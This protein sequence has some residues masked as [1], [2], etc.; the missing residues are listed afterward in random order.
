MRLPEFVTEISPVRETL[1][2]AGQGEKVLRADVKEAERQF[3]VSTATRGLSLWESDYS[4]ENQGPDEARRVAVWT[5]LAGGKTLTPEFLEELC[6]SLGKGDWGQ[7]NED[8]ANWTVTAYSAAEG[9]VP[10]GAAVLDAAIQRLK[11]AHLAVEAHPV[12]LFFPEADRRSALTGKQMAEI[13]GGDALSA[14]L[15]HG[16]A[17]TGGLCQEVFGGD[18]LL[19]EAAHMTALTGGV[20]REYCGDDGL[21]GGTTFHGTALTGCIMILLQG[22]VFP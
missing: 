18:Q 4:L 10:E 13:S 2:A 22:K 12:G 9:R 1:E 15:T 17:L 21:R 5:A 16:A 14:E 19:G 8:F 20:L 6:V 7:V 3:Y 11:P